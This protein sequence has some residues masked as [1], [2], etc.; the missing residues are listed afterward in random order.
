MSK[1]SLYMYLQLTNTRLCIETE[2]IKSRSV[3]S[4]YIY[5]NIVFVQ[6]LLPL[7]SVLMQYQK[8]VL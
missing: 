8:A 2:D 5:A 7:P 3:I 6:T 4:L 1:V